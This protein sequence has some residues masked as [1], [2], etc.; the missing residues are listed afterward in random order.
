MTINVHIIDL[1]FD[2][3]LSVLCIIDL[4]TV[5]VWDAPKSR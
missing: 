4:E 3:D 2:M 5:G 1:Y